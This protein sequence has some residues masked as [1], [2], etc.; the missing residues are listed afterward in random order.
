LRL[1]RRRF[2]LSHRTR[3]PRKSA[4][5]VVYGIGEMYHFSNRGRDIGDWTVLQFQPGYAELEKT[6]PHHC[7][8]EQGILTAGLAALDCPAVIA[9][10][11][12]FREGAESCVYTISSTRTDALWTGDG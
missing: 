1:G 6:T 9:Q 11:Q 8:M 3:V 2:E 12:C 4:R 7:V 5:D 10:T